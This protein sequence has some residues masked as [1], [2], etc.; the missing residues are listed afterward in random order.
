MDLLK[1]PQLEQS[2]PLDEWLAEKAPSD[3]SLFVASDTDINA[4]LP[5][6]DKANEMHIDF[7]VFSDGRGFSLA[8]ILRLKGYQ[9]TLVAVGDVTVDRVTY[10]QRVGFDRVQLKAGE[11]P[12]LVPKLVTQINHYYQGSSD[13]H[14]PIYKN[15]L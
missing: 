3:K 4:L 2:L 6:M 14:T 12:N 5:L 1:K 7:P 8:R 10:M 9:G 11:D 15:S 13:S